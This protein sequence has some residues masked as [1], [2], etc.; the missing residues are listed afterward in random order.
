M[1]LLFTASPSGAAD[2]HQGTHK[3]SPA[4]DRTDYP[5]LPKPGKKVLLEGGYSFV[6]SFDKSP[7]M[8][9]SILKIEVFDPSGKKDTTTFDIRGET[10]MPSMRGAHSSGSQPFKLSKKGD[11]LL[12]VNVVMPGGWEVRITILRNGK[13]VL[14]GTYGFDV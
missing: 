13:P 3:Q 8:G 2:P 5:H 12:P 4:A 14:R 6:Y 9:T 7:K 10:D 11:Y 1:L